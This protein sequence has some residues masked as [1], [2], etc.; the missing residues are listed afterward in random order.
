[1][2]RSRVTGAVECG[3]SKRPWGYAPGGRCSDSPAVCSIQNHCSGDSPSPGM[4]ATKPHL[5]L[6]TTEDCVWPSK[7]VSGHPLLRLRMYKD[8]GEEL[9]VQL[10]AKGRQGAGKEQGKRDLYEGFVWLDDSCKDFRG[11]VYWSYR[12][13]SAFSVRNSDGSARS[14]EA[15]TG[16]VTH[17]PRSGAT[18]SSVT[19][20]VTTRGALRPRHYSRVFIGSAVSL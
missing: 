2:L 12:G 7:T 3:V 17:L 18:A 20:C 8:R 4:G 5:P 19:G 15:T 13:F 14:E 1:M 11:N 9:S 16:L 6:R 10:W